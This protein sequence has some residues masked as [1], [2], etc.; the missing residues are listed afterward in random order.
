MPGATEHTKRNDDGKT[1]DNKGMM[2]HEINA[3]IWIIET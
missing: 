3:W 1:D 2:F